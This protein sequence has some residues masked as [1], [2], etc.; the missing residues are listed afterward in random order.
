MN[1]DDLLNKPY[2]CIL[3][4]VHLYVSPLGKLL[5]CCV[6]PNEAN[7]PMI[8]SDSFEK[9]FNS[10]Q[11]REL[12]FNMLN[13][14]PSE[15]CTY[16]YKLEGYG[17]HSHRK[18]ST[19]K[20]LN[21][22]P[23]LVDVVN[24]TSPDGKLEEINILYFD[25]RFSNVC[26]YKC[27]MCG[28]NYST[29]WYED[30]DLLGWSKK[31]K[32]PITSIKNIVNFCEQNKDFLKSIQYVYFAGGEP[33]VQTEHYEFLQWC[34]DNGVN[35]ELYYQS[36]GSILNYGKF[37]IFDLWKNFKKVTY[38]VSIDALGSL[39]EY[40]R[41]GYDD[42]KVNKN[43]TNICSY[44]GNNREITVNATF[45]A[46]NAFYATEFFDEMA[47][48]EWVMESNVYTQL[49]LYPE[50]L[51]PK[52]LPEPL[53]KE[54]IDKILKSKWYEKY[55][56][57]FEQLLSN[58]KDES[59]PELWKKFKEYTGKLDRRRGESLFDVFPEIKSYYD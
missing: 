14:K 51:Q 4:W 21:L 8:E 52:V 38:S 48:K 24:K 39:G 10:K 23:S 7:F 37:N 31:L 54:A 9:V 55:P 13:D 30:S 6:A 19:T 25:V 22:D 56:H 40:I 46:Y 17:A 42:E 35:P 36:N 28:S 57:K 45:M 2:F 11:M 59:T 33:L 26:N 20:A 50:H 43:L 27:R 15:V 44:F 3:P 32:E 49:L 12:R 5:P 47:E 16:C 34:V 53:K 1:K 41:S 58:L 29:K 18:H